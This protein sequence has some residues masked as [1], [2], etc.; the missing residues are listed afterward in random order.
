MTEP[1]KSS[2][3]LI[4]PVQFKF[5]LVSLGVF[6]FTWDK[7]GFWWGL[8]YWIVWPWHVGYRLAQWAL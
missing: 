7:Y 3:P 2:K 1:A 4:K 8:W 5:L 6:W